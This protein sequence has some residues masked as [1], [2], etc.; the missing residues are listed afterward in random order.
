MTEQATSNV[1]AADL[2]N[3]ADVSDLPEELRK[4]F[5]GE[6]TDNAKNY[7]DIVHRAAAAGHASLDINQI[8]AVALRLGYK[9]VGQQTVRNYLNKAVEL[10]LIG[11]PTRLTY[12]PDASVNA[13]DEPEA[14]AAE[15]TEEAKET[16][17]SKKADKVT[18]PVAEAADPLAGL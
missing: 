7:A 9:A 12:G 2:F 16:K 11:K 17:A 10:K 5:E 14:P 1:A 6:T 18:E 8:T 3:F 13:G 4:K 15:G